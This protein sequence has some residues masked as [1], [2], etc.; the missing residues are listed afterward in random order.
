MATTPATYRIRAAVPDWAD[1]SIWFCGP[2]GFGRAL[3]KDFVA[4]GLPPGRFHQEMFEM[5]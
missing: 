5:R 3:R 4:R 1:A 2:P